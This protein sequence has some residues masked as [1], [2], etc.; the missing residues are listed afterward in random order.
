M[1]NNK[2]KNMRKESRFFSEF[3]NRSGEDFIVRENPINLYNKIPMLFK[4]IA[5]GNVDLDKYTKYFC[6]KLI[7]IMYQRA[8]EI[9]QEKYVLMKALEL[10]LNQNPQDNVAGVLYMKAK[11]QVYAYNVLATGIQ[12][13]R[14]TSN[15]SYINT[16]ASSLRDVRFDV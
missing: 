13:I 11:K 2:V 5:F 1:K 16:M 7:E 15:L 6:P 8:I 10:Y 9:G 3:I 4:D 14:M 12:N